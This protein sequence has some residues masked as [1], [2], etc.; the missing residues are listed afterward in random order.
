MINIKSTVEKAKKKYPG[1][2]AGLDDEGIYNALRKRYPN[3]EW[4]EISPYELDREVNPNKDL[5]DASKQEPDPGAFS[6]IMLAGLPE[7]WADK[8][9]WAKNAYNNSMAGLIYQTTY[10]KPKYEVEEYDKEYSEG[11]SKL[12]EEIPNPIGVIPAVNVYNLRGNKRPIG[13]SDLSDVASA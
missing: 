1:Y 11:D 13:I 4:P 9:D 7:I 5:L 10:G 2:Y 3:E 12:L 8:H 6:N